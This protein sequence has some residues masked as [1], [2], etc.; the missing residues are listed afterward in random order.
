[1]IEDAEEKARF[2]D[3]ALAR[4]RPV[5]RPDHRHHWD[6]AEYIADFEGSEAATCRLAGTPEYASAS[7]VFATPDNCLRRFR[8]RTL[9]DGKRLLVATCGI[10]RG[11]LAL[12][13]TGLAPV[14]AALASTM[15][16]VDELAGPVSL[17]SI[18]ATWRPDLLVTG[19]L[20]VT[21]AGLRLGKGR[22]YFDL[23]W[24]MLREVG[25][26]AADAPVA[27]VV[28]DVQVVEAASTFPVRDHD[29]VADLVVTPA[30]LIRSGR[31]G[32]RA[33]RLDWSR[34]DEAKLAATPPLRELRER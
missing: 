10:G 6:L 25:A 8:E 24:A 27:V 1:M 22:G 31:T 3:D 26:V 4:L 30:A 18:A 17:G 34:V 19:A 9:L 28:H 29:V 21:R 15:E 16:A 2:R 5:A 7:V 14:D 11:F 20:A 33:A 12:D 32:P 23:E 13:G